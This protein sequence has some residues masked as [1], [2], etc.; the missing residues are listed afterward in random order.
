MF[1]KSSN[2]FNKFSKL[3][4]SNKYPFFLIISFGPFGQS[5]EIIGIFDNAASTI[6]KPGSS[7]SD[8]N[9]K[10]SALFRY[11]KIFF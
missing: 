5:L 9:I 8:V 1:K 3:L 6:T 2:F 7:Q 4:F 11:L 10:H